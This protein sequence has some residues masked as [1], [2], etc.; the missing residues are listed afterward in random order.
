VRVILTGQYLVKGSVG[1]HTDQTTQIFSQRNKNIFSFT[2]LWQK[3][4]QLPHQK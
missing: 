4:R 2:R 3:S 1:I